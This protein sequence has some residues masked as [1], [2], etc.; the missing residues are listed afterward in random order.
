VGDQ[1]AEEGGRGTIGCCE[2]MSD[3]QCRYAHVRVIENHNARV[4]VHWRYA[5]CDVL[6]KIAREDKLTGWGAWADEYYYIYP[7]CAAVRYF[8]VHGV[9][10]CSITEPAALNNPGEKV[11]DNLNVEAITTATMAGEIRSHSWDR[12]PSSGRTGA[13]FTN[14][15]PNAN[16]CL[17]NFK[18]VSRPYYI[19]EPGTSIIPYGG[20][21]KELRREYSKFP[22]WNHWPTSM[23]PSDG[24]YPVVADRVT[25]SAVTSPEPPMKQRRDG[26]VEGRFIMGLTDKPIEKLAPLARSWLKPPQLKIVTKGF[27]G[28]GYSRDQRAYILV[29]ET[30]QE[31]KLD[32]ELSASEQSPVI[33]PAF[34]IRN[35]GQAGGL[36]KI[37]DKS[38]ERGRDFRLGH[39]HTPDGTNLVVWIK[40]ESTKPVRVSISPVAQ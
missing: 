26:S 9:D 25:S 4:V 28:E 20:G 29:K 15:L 8:R 34:V 36:L 30:K 32:F 13:P 21:T 39:D 10:E 18:S 27:S 3:K 19:Y 24:F 12:W 6:Y 5:L 1:S 31:A 40:I 17:V 33:N 11:E 23:D 22:T 7:D 38:I 16:I 37:D 14:A 2:H 35:W